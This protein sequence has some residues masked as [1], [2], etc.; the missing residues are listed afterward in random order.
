MQA[1][2][3]AQDLYGN[4]ASKAVCV[5]LTPPSI[6]AIVLKCSQNC[7]S[8]VIKGILEFS[9]TSPGSITFIIV[10]TEDAIPLRASDLLAGNY[11]GMT[12]QARGRVDIPEM[13][14][15]GTFPF[16]H[17]A[18]RNYTIITA[19]QFYTADRCTGMYPVLLISIAV[20]CCTL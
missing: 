11:N 8:L 16:N 4:T 1:C 19:A 3:V 9:V 12:V 14:V 13:E 18:G 17:K 20:P 7:E 10:F 15:L 6:Q 2:C 5:P